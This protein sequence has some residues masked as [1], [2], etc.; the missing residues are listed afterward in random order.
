MCAY[1][2]AYAYAYIIAIANTVAYIVANA[3]NASSI[4]DVGNSLI[5]VR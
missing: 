5:C 3:Y 2:V 4:T 1:I